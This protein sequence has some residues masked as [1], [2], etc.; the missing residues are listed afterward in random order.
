MKSGNQYLF[1]IMCTATHF[2][3]AGLLRNIKAPK[4]VGELVKLFTFVGLP[5]TVQSD[6]GSNFMFGLVQQTMYQLGVK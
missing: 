6:Q 5:C 3:E 1:T 2:P 4:I